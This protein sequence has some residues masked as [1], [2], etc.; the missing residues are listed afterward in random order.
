MQKYGFSELSEF[1]LFKLFFGKISISFFTF[2]SFN[3]NN[4]FCILGEDLSFVLTFTNIK[5]KTY[6]RKFPGSL[7]RQCNV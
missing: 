2:Y 1:G 3:T 7:F 5:L 6:P 4:K